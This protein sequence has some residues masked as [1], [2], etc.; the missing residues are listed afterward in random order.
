MDWQ[1]IGSNRRS[2]QVH[3]PKRQPGGL[4]RDS[5]PPATHHGPLMQLETGEHKLRSKTLQP[6]S[7][8]CGAPT[9]APGAAGLSKEHP[10]H[11]TAKPRAREAT[12][13]VG[14]NGVCPKFEWGR[15]YKPNAFKDK[16][17]PVPPSFEQEK[18]S[19]PKNLIN[20]GAP[21]PTPV[22]FGK[23]SQASGG[24]P[25][26]CSIDHLRSTC[27]RVLPGAGNLLAKIPGSP[28]SPVSWPVVLCFLQTEACLG[29]RWRG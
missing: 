15:K 23:L 29:A 9:R 3:Q 27:S 1:W 2:T 17:T 11:V 18:R 8:D 25:Q 24:S 10:V 13:R 28:L 16:L 26:R 21:A 12:P 4:L 14:T 22:L 5:K 20:P 7:G 19:P 6:V